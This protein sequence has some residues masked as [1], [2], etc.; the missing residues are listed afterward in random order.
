MYRVGTWACPRHPS[1]WFQYRLVVVVASGLAGRGGLWTRR[2][3]V[4]TVVAM[5][6][7]G[8]DSSG[9]RLLGTCARLPSHHEAYSSS[10][11]AAHSQHLLRKVMGL[12]LYASCA[13]SVGRQRVPIMTITLHCEK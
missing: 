11:T 12:S 10:M 8:H 13:S 2:Q 3:D 5:C 9:L 1:I 4:T 7:C 6:Y